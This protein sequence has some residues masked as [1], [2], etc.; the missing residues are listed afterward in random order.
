MA[1]LNTNALYKMIQDQATQAEGVKQAALN[2]PTF[3]NQFGT[4]LREQDKTLSGAIGAYSDKV[5]ELFAHDKYVADNWSTPTTPASITPTGFMEDPYAKAKASAN[6]YAQKGSE[7]ASSLKLLETRKAVLGDLVDK[8]MKMYDSAVKGKQL[9]LQAKESEFANSLALYKQ[10]KDEEQQGKQLALEYAKLK[11]SGLA[12]NDISE[13]GI[14]NIDNLSDENA[15]ALA[16]QYF[17]PNSVKGGTQPGRGAYARGLLKQIKEGKIDLKVVNS[18]LDKQ[19]SDLVRDAANFIKDAQKAQTAFGT[20][21]QGYW[22]SYLEG[23]TGP[24]GG[25]GIGAS[26][27]KADLLNLLKRMKAETIKEYYGSAFTTTEMKNAGWIID[28]KQQEFQN[29]SAL[30]NAEEAAYNKMYSALK[31]SGMD[32]SMVDLV[33]KSYGIKSY[34]EYKT[35]QTGTIN[36]RPSISSFDKP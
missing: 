33:M 13:I 34:S 4:T 28:A 12:V 17:G 18:T 10:V 27:E 2:A 20:T 26:K 32:D 29:L 22:K 8:A 3:E 7:V 9:D 30:R 31:S 35:P 25:L 11:P 14:S 24:I 36:N 1:D 19:Q 6:L 21:G 23:T 16:K 15:E 5:A